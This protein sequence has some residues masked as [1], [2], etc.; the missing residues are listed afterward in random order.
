MIPGDSVPNFNV[1]ANLNSNSNFRF[2][3]PLQLSIPIVTATYISTSTFT[4]PQLSLRRGP[5]HN[6]GTTWQTGVSTLPNFSTSHLLNF[7]LLNLSTSNFS[8][9]KLPNFTTSQLLN[10]TTSQLPNS[11][12]SYPHPHLHQYQIIT[13]G[14]VWRGRG[15]ATLQKPLEFLDFWR[16]PRRALWE[17]G[18]RRHVRSSMVIRGLGCRDPLCARDR[19]ENSMKKSSAS[20]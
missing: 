10:F 6:S 13:E 1:N 12:S 16:G 3:L 20:W 18:R 14:E 2:E 17:I 5:L 7:Q 4:S 9:S 11:S 15:S 19:N 8:T